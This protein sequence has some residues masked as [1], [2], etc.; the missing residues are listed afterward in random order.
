MSD[1]KRLGEFE[2]IERYFAP[3]A[4]EGTF[5]LKDDAAL[6]RVTPGKVLVVTQDA[7]AE[8]THFLPGNPPVTVAKKALRVNLSDLAAKG[9]VPTAFSL[10]LG[11]GTDWHEDWL[12]DFAR[13]LAEDCRQYGLVL[14]GG[15]TFR[16]GG[17]PVISITAWGEIDE[18]DYRSRLTAKPGDR[19][20]VTGTIGEGAL[21][22][23]AHK[24][25]LPDVSPKVQ[26]VMERR[27]FVPEPP[28]SFAPLIA[29]FASASMDVSDGFVGDLAKMAVASGFDIDVEQAA[30]PFSDE[31]RGILEDAGADS[32]RLLEVA[33]TGGDDYQILFT[34][35]E[36]RV[37]SFLEK[38]QKAATAVAELGA[39]RAGSGKVS[40]TGDD[41]EPLAFASASWRHF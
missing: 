10:A 26:T 11:L 15:D 22:L 40:V 41:G 12:E 24:G 31:V 30:I 18:A 27:Y 36:S 34:V 32:L 1:E 8:P 2:L 6:L 9:A 23:L 35:P 4:G 28:V 39:V 29:E 25:E 37:A 17:G 13:G 21:G 19:L 38:A 16:T 5:G 33:L 7:I 20:F 14:S 3:L